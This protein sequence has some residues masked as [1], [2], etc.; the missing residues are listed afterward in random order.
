MTLKEEYGD[1]IPCKECIHKKVCN[2]KTCFEETRYETTH[3]YV[4]IDVKCTEFI[5]DKIPT[6]RN[7]EVGVENE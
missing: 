6:P 5:Y 4:D 1:K 2:V 7:R 3:P